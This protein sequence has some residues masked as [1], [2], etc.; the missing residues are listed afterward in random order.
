MPLRS[1][2]G[3]QGPL[4]RNTAKEWLNAAAEKVPRYST[5]IAEGKFTAF[6]GVLEKNVKEGRGRIRIKAKMRR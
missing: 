3:G 1:A 2:R 5:T 6:E 4:S